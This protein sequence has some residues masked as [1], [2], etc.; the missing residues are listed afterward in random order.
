MAYLAENSQRLRVRTSLIDNKAQL[1]DCAQGF[2][3]VCIVRLPYAKPH[4]PRPALEEVGQV[5]REVAHVLGPEASLVILGEPINLV[6]AHASVEPFLRYQLWIA[7]KRKTICSSTTPGSLPQ[8][9]FGAL[10]YTKYKASLR[11][12]KTR[13][14]YT[15]CPVCNKTTKDYGGKKHT[16]HEFGTL[17]SDVWRDV[18]CDLESNLTPV[19]DRFADL[20]GSEPYRELL[21]LDC[22]DLSLSYALPHRESR[23][24]V[25]EGRRTLETRSHALIQGNCLEELKKIPNDSID[26]VFADPP[27]NLRK[28]YS[29]YNDG[30]QIAEYFQWCDQWIGE[31]AR[32]LRPGR[33]CAILNIPLWAIRYFLCLEKIMRFQNWVVWDS[34]SFP[35]RLIMPAHYTI[36]CFSKGESRPLPGLTDQADHENGFSPYNGFQPYRPLAEGYC[37][38]ANCVATRKALGLNDRGPLTDLWGDVHRL[39]HNSR[40]VDHPCQLPPQLMYRLLSLFTKPG[41]VVLDCFNGAGT[42]TLAAHQFNRAYIGI[43]L[44]EQYHCLAQARHEEIGMGLDPFRK[45]KRTLTSKNSPVPRMPKQKYAVPKKT[46]QLEVKRVAR[47]LGRIPSR[48]DIR[49]LGKYPIEYYEKYFASWGEVCAAARTTGMSEDRVPVK[50]EPAGQQLELFVRERKATYKIGTLANR[51]LG[52]RNGKSK[53]LRTLLKERAEDLKREERKRKPLRK[54]T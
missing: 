28:K 48:E 36:L 45:E 37:L 15:Y 39:K 4:D 5:V 12:V 18:A 32:V 27:Y 16:Y 22:R 52:S 41:E 26:F 35:V 17:V 50:A 10:V 24:V 13:I 30:L 3:D 34:L 47:L 19:I 8:Y 21:F 2:K 40:R 54:K 46:L 38:R 29:G 1:L 7:I 25:Q 31:L 44:S 23:P 53:V 6:H 20:F 9:H 42:T 11:H 43:E 51:R 14:Q 49:K 33:T